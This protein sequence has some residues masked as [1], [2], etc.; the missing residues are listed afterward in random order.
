VDRARRP[1][2][3]RSRPR[4]ASNCLDLPTSGCG[5]GLRARASGRC[6]QHSR[7]SPSATA[8]PQSPARD[9]RAPRVIRAP[10]PGRDH[11]VEPRT[12][13]G[14]GNPIGDSLEIDRVTTDDLA[15]AGADTHTPDG[16]RAVSWRRRP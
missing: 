6:D 15:L 1:G 3:G 9:L 4:P 13:N 5:I 2:L 11:N 8:S 12:E 14:Q 16:S 7:H 10:E